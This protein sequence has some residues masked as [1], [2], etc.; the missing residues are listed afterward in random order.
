[1]LNREKRRVTDKLLSIGIATHKCAKRHTAFAILRKLY[2]PLYL[3]NYPF[4]SY[5]KNYCSEYEYYDYIG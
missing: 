4:K 1:M 2:V 5:G 3:K